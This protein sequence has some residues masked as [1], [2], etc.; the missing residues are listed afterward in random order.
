MAVDDCV[1]SPR[2]RKL[3]SRRFAAILPVFATLLALSGCWVYSVNPLYEDNLPK[4]DP[5][6][7]FDASLVGSWGHMDDSCLWILTVGGGGA[8]YGMT[9]TP[10]TGCKSD[11]KTTKY[12]GHL[13]KLGNHRFLDFSPESGEVC[14]LC[15][16]LHSFFLVSQEND[17]LA[18]IPIDVQWL[19]QAINQRKVGLAHLP[20]KN[21]T[22]DAVVLT[23]T[24]EAL[25]EFV[26]KYADDKAAFKPD[27]DATL[28]FKKR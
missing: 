4:P 2:K 22:D 27:S 15:L 6:L 16:P 21:S 1:G 19:S 11:E 7:V 14:D 24:S 26:R 28:K 23:A 18:L 25:K 17:S 12:A 3:L 9:M 5:D 13:V 10:S 8:P 20:S